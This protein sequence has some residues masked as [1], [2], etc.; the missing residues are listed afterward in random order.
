[1]KSPSPERKVASIPPFG[2][3]MQT[4]LKQQIE[5][6][7]RASGRSLNAEIV[8]RLEQSFGAGQDGSSWLKTVQKTTKKASET[9]DRILALEKQV[10]E[11]IKGSKL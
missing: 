10:A 8:W 3:R 9:E 2:L 5:A 4:E 11:I 1:M 7:A 6:Q